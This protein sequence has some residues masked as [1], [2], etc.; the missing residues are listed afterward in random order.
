MQGTPLKSPL[1]DED[2]EL[3]SADEIAEELE[4]FLAIR[5]AGDDDAGPSLGL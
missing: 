5:R 4:K 1:T 3:P 2:G